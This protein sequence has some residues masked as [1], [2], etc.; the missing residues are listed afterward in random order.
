MLVKDPINHY[1]SPLITI[2]SF[3]NQKEYHYD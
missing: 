1:G 2:N 3:M